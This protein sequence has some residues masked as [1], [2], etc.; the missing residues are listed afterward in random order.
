MSSFSKCF[1]PALQVRQRL[2]IMLR[3][4]I[5]YLVNQLQHSERLDVVWDTYVAGSLKESTREKRGTGTRRK[6]SGQAKL[7]ANWIQ[8][9]RNSTN[10]TE[11]FQFLT[12]KV[13]LL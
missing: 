12:E 11:L 10:K 2:T 3:V 13:A 8:F 5:P 7:P 4:F 9:L 1:P 6:V